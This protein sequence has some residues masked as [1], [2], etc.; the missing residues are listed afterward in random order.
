MTLSC[1]PVLLYSCTPVLLYSCTSVLLY[2]CTALD[3]VCPGCLCGRNTDL[4]I[5]TPPWSTLY[6]MGKFSAV[7]GTFKTLFGILTKQASAFQPRCAVACDSVAVQSPVLAKFQQLV[8]CGGRNKA[9][10]CGVR[11]S[12]CQGVRVWGR[13]RAVSCRPTI[14]RKCR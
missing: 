3:S 12:G 5:V 7:F 13:S 4:T 10:W 14:Q 2:S 11:V 6:A 8:W 1:T 9:V